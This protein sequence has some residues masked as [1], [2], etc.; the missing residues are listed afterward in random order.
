[1]Q[2]FT[3]TADDATYFTVPGNDISGKTL[4][5]LGVD[6]DLGAVYLSPVTRNG[7]RRTI[8]LRCSVETFDELVRAYLLVRAAQYSTEQV[9]RLVDS[10]IAA[11]RFVGVNESEWL[12]TLIGRATDGLEDGLEVATSKTDLAPKD[13]LLL[14]IATMLQ[15]LS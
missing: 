4:R 13:A 3:V 15:R 14:V 5:G 6:I 8:G 11:D 12:A 1:M 9:C 2:S 10:V 7:V